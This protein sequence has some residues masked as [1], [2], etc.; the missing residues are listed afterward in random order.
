MLRRAEEAKQRA[1]DD[2]NYA[3]AKSARRAEIQLELI[4]KQIKDVERAKVK[5][6]D[7]DDFDRAQELTEQLKALRDNAFEQVDIKFL[8]SIPVIATFQAKTNLE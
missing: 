6:I 1:V 7:E 8:N 3:L 2:E 4:L 5:A